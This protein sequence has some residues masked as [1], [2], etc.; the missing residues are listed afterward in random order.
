MRPQGSKTITRESVQPAPRRG[1][2]DAGRVRAG[3]AR[4]EADSLRE[5]LDE[6]HARIRILQEA[7][8]RL[9]VQV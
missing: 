2:Q 5:L 8:Y 9:T 3:S 1:A 7:I 4:R 6:A